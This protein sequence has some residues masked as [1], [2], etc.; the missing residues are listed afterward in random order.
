MSVQSMITMMVCLVPIWGGL[1][2]YLVKLVR[3]EDAGESC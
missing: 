3:L 1:V 2:S